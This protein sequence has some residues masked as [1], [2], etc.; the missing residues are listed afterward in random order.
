MSDISKNK[1]QELLNLASKKL[2]TS[3]EELQ[4]KIE[5]NPSELLKN[6]NSQQASKIQQLLKNPEIAQQLASSEQI[7]ELL[8]KAL[9]N[10]NG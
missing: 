10:K 6:L 1:L 9:E 8:K 3:P 5:S 7:K 4:K 2:G